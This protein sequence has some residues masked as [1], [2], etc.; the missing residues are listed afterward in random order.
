MT[1][2]LAHEYD[3]VSDKERAE[4]SR[5]VY[6][7]VLSGKGCPHCGYKHK[8]DGPHRETQLRALVVDGVTDDDPMEFF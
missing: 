2:I 3:R 4:V 8:D 7:A 1:L 6:H 5:A